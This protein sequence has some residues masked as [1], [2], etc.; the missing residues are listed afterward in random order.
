MELSEI[1]DNIRKWYQISN[2]YALR[3]CTGTRALAAHRIA[4]R[5]MG[6]AT[7]TYWNFII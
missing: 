1:G 7:L 4:E 3:A 2:K 6:L 5:T